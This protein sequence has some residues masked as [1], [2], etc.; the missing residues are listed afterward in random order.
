M[1]A[2][3]RG[4]RVGLCL[5]FA[6]AGMLAAGGQGR[7]RAQGDAVGELVAAAEPDVRAAIDARPLAVRVAL[8]SLLARGAIPREQLAE[9]LGKKVLAPY[10]VETL[11]ALAQVDGVTGAGETFERLLK[12]GDDGGVRGSAF[13]LQAAAALGER[14]VAIGAVVDGNEV[15]LLLVDGTRVEV[16]NDAPD[17][18]SELSDSLAKKAI[19]QLAKRGAFGSPVMLVANEPLAAE[20]LASFRR[21]LGPRSEVIVLAGGRLTAQLERGVEGRG[22]RARRVALGALRKTLY[23]GKTRAASALK[24]AVKLMRRL[25]PKRMAAKRRWQRAQRAAR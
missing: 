13:E 1:G 10:V 15:D 16:K 4:R 3:M 24:P 17:E 18:R 22:Q 14:V 21:R 8:E 2:T 12:A 5:L 6:L 11:S 23:R 19:Q 7:A 25:G 20:T 9:A